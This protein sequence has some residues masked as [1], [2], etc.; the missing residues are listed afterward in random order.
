MVA[1]LAK[2]MRNQDLRRRSKATSGLQTDA[3][4]GIRGVAT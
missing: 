2:L 4:H 3:G 1:A